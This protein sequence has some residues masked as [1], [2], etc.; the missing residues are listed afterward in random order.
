MSLSTAAQRAFFTGIGST[1]LKGD[2]MLI[3][4]LGQVLERAQRKWPTVQ[5]PDEVFFERLGERVRDSSG[6][7][8][9]LNRLRTSDLY[10]AWAAA[11][12]DE[13]AMAAIIDHARPTLAE[14]LAP[15]RLAAH[16]QD[17]LLQRLRERVFVGTTPRIGTYSGTG[18]ISTWLSAAVVRLAVDSKRAEKPQ[19]ELDDEL[20]NSVAD[21]SDVELSVIRKQ[22]Q[23]EFRV[24]FQEAF[25]ELTLDERNLVRLTFIDRLSIDALA[26]MT[27]LHR[28]TVA[29]RISGLRD[30][31][32]KGT[33]RRLQERFKLTGSD[34]NSLMRVV[35]TAFDA[36]LSSLLG[37]AGKPKP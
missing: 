21:G 19:D 26:A 11:R 1:A 25:R 14:A 2:S 3:S 5:L 37:E 35:V 31:L 22:F 36:S 16:E 34:M 13:A 10:A 30:E 12:G 17:E 33:R 23:G 32:A 20:A 27:G 8:G 4:A 7:V 15:M 24:A 28:S 18:S 29:R 9:L 6:V